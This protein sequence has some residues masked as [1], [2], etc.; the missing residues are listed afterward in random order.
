MKAKILIDD[1]SNRFKCGDIG[2]MVDNDFDKYDYR[3]E[4]EDGRAYYFY[5]DEIEVIS[6][7]L[8]EGNK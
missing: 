1:S 6:D 7:K 3:I 5:K 4:L 8:T 2:L